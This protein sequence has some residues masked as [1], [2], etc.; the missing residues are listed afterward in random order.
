MASLETA[1]IMKEGAKHVENWL[2]KNE[3]TSVKKETWQT[4][5]VDIQAD[6][7]GKN[8]FIQVH[9]V[10][11]PNEPVVLKGT[12]KFA[13]KDLAARLNRVP[14]IAYLVIDEN[15]NLVG[16]IDWERLS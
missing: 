8:I 7:L 6:S 16:E 13:V 5:S 11:H 9:T 15:K 2:N 4:G 12:D 3:Y 10:L 14:Y 1:E